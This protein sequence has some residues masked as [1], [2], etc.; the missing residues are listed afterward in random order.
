MKN[1]FNILLLAFF[2][3]IVACEPNNPF[4]TGPAYDVEGNLA[5][6]SVKIAAYLDTAQ[7]DSL[8]RIHDPSGVIIIVQEEGVG[9]RP[10]GGNVV[11]T[12][13]I[14]SLME[15]GSVFDTNLET[16]ARENDLYVEGKDYNLF[17]F[18]FG[19]KEVITGWDIAFG[20]LRPGSKARFVI[21]S[22]YGYQDSENRSRIPAN[23][24]LIFDIDFKGTD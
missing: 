7:I 6:D 5:I 12:D 23:S 22:P 20:R 16:V 15:D 24:I 4:N 9:S 2:G 19:I 21:P 3:A 18:K 13:F 1:L 14:G 17:R 11:Y 8:Y 10:T